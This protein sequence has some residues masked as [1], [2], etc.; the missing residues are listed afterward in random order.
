MTVTALISNQIATT[1][2]TDAP[3]TSTAS[4]VISPTTD[5]VSHSLSPYSMTI[6]NTSP[7]SSDHVDGIDITIPTGYLSVVLGTISTVSAGKNWTASIVAG[8]TIH[9]VAN[10]NPDR[11]N[12]TDSL[13]LNFTATS[14]SSNGIYTWTTTTLI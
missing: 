11:L 5:F 14:P 1:T 9:L 12:Q 7:N 4:S 6:T 3:A 2:F 8:T 10:A 13:T